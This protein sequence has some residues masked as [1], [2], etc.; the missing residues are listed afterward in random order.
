MSKSVYIEDIFDRF[1]S[2]ISLQQLLVSDQD[3]TATY[4]L[5]E[6]CVND[7]KSLTSNQANYLLKILSRYK[8]ES[9]DL[10]LDYKLEILNPVWKKP[11]RTLDLSKK[12][13]VEV[14]EQKKIWIC[15]KFPFALK[16]IF[17]NEIKNE[18]SNSEN[19]RWDQEKK[20]RM[21][22]AYKHNIMHINEF[23]NYHN[24]DI[25]NTF[26]DLVSSVEEI[27]Q[28]QDSITPYACIHGDKVMLVNAVDDAI[29]AFETKKTN[30]YEQDIFLAKTMGF[31]LNLEK[32]PTT[33]VESVSVNSANQFW[34]KANSKFFDLHKSA[35]GRSAVVLDK[36]TKDLLEWLKQ[37]VSD[38]DIAGC[39]DEIKI[40]FRESEKENS[41]INSWIK[42]NRLGGKVDEGNIYVFLQKPPKWLF[43]N[44]IDVKIIGTN[45]Y[46]P[47][48]SD[49]IVSAWIFNHPCLC[50]LGDVKPTVI[51]NFKI[52]N[53]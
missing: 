19:N 53:L 11:F 42:E 44:K 15:L 18:R 9:F 51:R 20:L 32:P 52:V 46:V 4:S 37:F 17:D 2:L 41:Q 1:H 10:G 22:E 36:N 14:D 12:V 26:L 3:L 43:K 23:V 30:I 13:F 6:Y 25:D 50:Y 27:W 34:L 40:C 5:Y 38:A 47:P 28:Q 21:I 7:E 16:E 49:A 48:L 35:G 24:F 33:L 39:K 45:C 8:N 31:V 29:K